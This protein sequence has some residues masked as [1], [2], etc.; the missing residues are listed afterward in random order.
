MRFLVNTKYICRRRTGRVLSHGRKRF[1]W[2]RKRSSKRKGWLCYELC[3]NVCKRSCLQRSKFLANK[4]TCSLFNEGQQARK[5]ERFVKRDGSFYIEKVFL[6]FC[7]FF[8]FTLYYHFFLYSLRLQRRGMRAGYF[9]QFY[10]MVIV[11]VNVSISFSLSF[12]L[13]RK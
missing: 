3:S 2:W 11:H 9:R 5:M 7:R 10:A 1:P 8:R 13:S 4:G 6:E 12:P